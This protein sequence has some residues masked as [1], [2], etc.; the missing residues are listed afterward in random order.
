VGSLA[1][2]DNTTPP[3]FD[4][5]I[6][7][8]KCIA[9]SR[10]HKCTST[11]GSHPSTTPAVAPPPFG[12]AAHNHYAPFYSRWQP[13]T[14]A[15]VDSSLD[16]DAYVAREA[17]G[18]D[19]PPIG[20][21]F[22]GYRGS[23]LY[24]YWQFVDVLSSAEDGPTHC[25]Q[26]NDSYGNPIY[27]SQP[28]GPQDVLLF[29]D[30]HGEAQAY[31]NPGTGFFFDN[32]VQ[33]NG[34]GGCDLRGI[35]TLGTA[36]ISAVAR[37]PYQKTTD[38]DK[39]SGTIRKTVTSLFNKSVTCTPKSGLTGPE[40][41]TAFICTATAIDID[42]T[43]F[44]NEKVCFT[45]GG[46]GAEVIFPF[47][48]TAHAERLG[49]FTLC[50]WTDANGQAQVEII[51][52]CGTGNVFAVF[53]D[54]GI[55]RVFGP[56]TF[57]CPTGG[58][59]GGGTTTTTTTVGAPGSAAP[60]GVVSV[61]AAPNSVTQQIVATA[62]ANGG[63]AAGT[64]VKP[65]AANPKARLAVVRIQ[66]KLFAKQTARYVLVRVNGTAKTARVQVTL[67]KRN[68]KTL[69]KVTRSV[70]TNKLVRV[71]NLK[72]PSAALHARVRLVS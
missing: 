29:S 15:T 11:T 3:G 47:P 33:P 9:Y 35:T 43:P 52:K 54:E 24:D 17:S 44:A 56:F 58:G 41:N 5:Y 37:Y 7:V 61:P 18:N 57:G 22:P 10:D 71:P 63:T 20:N 69:S 2:I 26:R 4:P 23:G 40:A 59:G 19:G 30:E 45:T 42:G 65:A 60:A 38:P 51:G 31:F 12:P 46:T 49:D 72:L 68:G 34:N 14:F 21:N 64:A 66:K 55:L 6:G 1:I 70:P 67:V 32:L 50:V 27:R 13:A 25:L 8:F 53:V 28:V 62:R 39:P 48:I 16:S 36:D